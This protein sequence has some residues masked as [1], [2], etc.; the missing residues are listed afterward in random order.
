MPFAKAW[1]IYPPLP[2]AA[3]MMSAS[4]RAISP[5]VLMPMRARRTEVLRPTMRR[6]EAG[7]GQ[8]ISRKCSRSMTVTA[9]GFL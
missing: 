7:S 5:M 6:S 1:S 3:P 8:T 9:S 2:K 4:V